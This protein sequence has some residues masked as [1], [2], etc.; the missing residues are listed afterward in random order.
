MLAV[1]LVSGLFNGL[2]VATA[3]EVGDFYTGD[4]RV[5]PGK[6]GVAPDAAWEGPVLDAARAALG[7]AAHA[8]LETELILSRRSLVQ[9]YLEEQDQYQIAG[10]GLGGDATR[11]FGL[12]ILVGLD[13]TDPMRDRVRAHLVAGRLPAPNAERIEVVL[14]LEAFSGYLSAAERANLSAWPPRA[15]E[16][17]AFGF[18]ATSGYVDTSGF[19]KDIVRR[20]TVVVGLF[21]T[22]LDALDSL[23]AVAEMAGARQ[24]QGNATQRANVFTV[25]GDTAQARHAAALHGWQVEDGAAFSDR[26]LGQLLGTVRALSLLAVGLFL[27]VPAFLLWHGLQQTLDLQRR[28]IAVCRA[29]GIGRPVLAAALARLAWRV[30]GVG[31]LLAAVAAALLQLVLPSLLRGTSLL[32]LPLDFRLDPAVAVA[33]LLVV[34]ASTWVALR[35]A[36]RASALQP[37]A[38][39]LRSA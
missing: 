38:A 5:T 8:R 29:I 27:A 15:A 12:G 37:L 3:R 39:A 20:P 19:F 18:E 24:L 32:P 35:L 7:P 9:A 23:T 26:Y 6:P 10:P 13:G 14:G 33:A 34:A 28:E 22:G 4:L 16:L 17:A 31:L 2:Q 30:A 21:A 36:R 1:L 11:H 25:T